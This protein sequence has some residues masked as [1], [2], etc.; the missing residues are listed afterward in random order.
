LDGF[1]A[2]V[3]G[4][5][6]ATPTGLAAGPGNTYYAGNFDPETCSSDPSC[7]RCDP[8]SPDLWCSPSQPA[9][10]HGGGPLGRIAEFTLPSEGVEPR[11]RIVAVLPGEEVLALAASGDGSVLVGTYVSASSGRVHRLAPGGDLTLLSQL[12]AAYSITE[13]R[14]RDDLYV[15]I[16]GTPKIHRLSTTGGALTLPSGVP[17]DPA[18]TGVLQYGPD[19]QLYRLV[20]VPNGTSSLAGYALD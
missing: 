15:E 11:F 18:G 14:Q 13:D 6:V 17:A 12:A 3:S 5:L 16:L 20:G 19:R 2:T 1:A 4:I 7:V 8:S 9:C 10:C